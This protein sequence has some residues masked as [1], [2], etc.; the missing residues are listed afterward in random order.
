MSEPTETQSEE[1]LLAL[2]VAAIDSIS[3]LSERVTVLE[4]DSPNEI[5]GQLALF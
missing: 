1:A 5:P 4:S 3:Q 2:V